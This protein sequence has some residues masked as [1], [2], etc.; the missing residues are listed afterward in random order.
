MIK[1]KVKAMDPIHHLAMPSIARALP[2]YHQRDIAVTISQ[3][4]TGAES[5]DSY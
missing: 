2:V 3:M 1:T 5:E 4:P